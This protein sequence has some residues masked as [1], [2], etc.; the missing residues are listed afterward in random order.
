MNSQNIQNVK[1]RLEFVSKLTSVKEAFR[2][3][4]LIEHTENNGWTH[5]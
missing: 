4:D 3:H 5:E 1:S 2:G